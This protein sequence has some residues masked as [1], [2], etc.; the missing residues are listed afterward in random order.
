MKKKGKKG[1][2]KRSAGQQQA[3]NLDQDVTEWQTLVEEEDKADDT[4]DDTRRET[5]SGRQQ[6]S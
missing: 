6:E 4:A 3:D 2:S 5:G 1:W